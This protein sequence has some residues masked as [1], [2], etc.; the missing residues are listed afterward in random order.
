L[1]DTNQ[2]AAGHW[3]DRHSSAIWG[4]IVG[5]VPAALTYVFGKRVGRRQTTHKAIQIASSAPDNASIADQ[6]QALAP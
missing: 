6:L 1:N 4:F 2:A 5:I 3:F